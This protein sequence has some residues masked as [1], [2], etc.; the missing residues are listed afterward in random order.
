MANIPTDT[1]LQ[2]LSRLLQVDKESPPTLRA[3]IGRIT[4]CAALLVDIVQKLQEVRK[5]NVNIIYGEFIEL[6]C[7]IDIILR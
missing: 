3:M 5:F 1:V 4:K 7:N 2:N 6:R